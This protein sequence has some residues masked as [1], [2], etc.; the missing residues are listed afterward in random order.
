[1][2]F[3]DTN[4]LLYAVTA[5]PEEAKNGQSLATSFAKIA[6]PFL[7]KSCRSFMFKPLE[8]VGPTL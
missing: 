4:I 3:L 6:W 7:F 5:A 2:T 8:P 1:M